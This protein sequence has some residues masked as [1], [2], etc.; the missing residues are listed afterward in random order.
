MAAAQEKR[1]APLELFFDLVFVFA[2][3]QVTAFM[4]HDPWESLGQG[5][6]ILSALWWAWAAYAWLTNYI[7]AEEDLR[8]APDA[9]RDG[10]LAGRRAGRAGGVGD[11]ALLF[12]I[13]YAAARWLHIFIFAQ[14]NDDVDAEKA[15]RQLSRTTL[16]APL[17]LI[18]RRVTRQRRPERSS[19]WL[20]LSTDFS[21]PY[22]SGVRGSACTPAH[23]AER[24]SLIVIIALGGSIAAVGPASAAGST[25]TRS[26]RRC[27]AP[28]SPSGIWWADLD[29]VAIV[30]ERQLP[31][32]AQG[33]RRLKLAAT[34][35]RPSTCPM[36]AGHRADRARR[37]E[38]RRHVDEPLETMPAV[39]LLGGVALY[40]AGGV[41]LPAA[42]RR[43]RSTAPA[44]RGSLTVSR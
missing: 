21:G 38:G 42:E 23:F 30:A 19:G 20:A 22:I 33:L 16:P 32:R 12:A 37:E 34:P 7:A 24:F 9:R 27:S 13:A 44:F 28:C 35:A 5:M 6:L 3:T 29:V 15:I 26:P 1:V 11:D 2:I 40:Y 4:S 25:P 41:G 36:I 18:E 14:A 43:G 31:A 8:A 39:A 10:C 17:L